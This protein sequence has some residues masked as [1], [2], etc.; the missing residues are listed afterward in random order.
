MLKL[1]AHS[2]YQVIRLYRNWHVCTNSA[3]KTRWEEPIKHA[4]LTLAKAD[5][6]IHCQVVRETI[7]DLNKGVLLDDADKGQPNPE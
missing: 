1:I 4:I 6:E 5:E 3:I 2:I 7:A